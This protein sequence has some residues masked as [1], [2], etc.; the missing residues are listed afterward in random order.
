MESRENALKNLAAIEVRYHAFFK[1]R[2]LHIMDCVKI[3]GKKLVSVHVVNQ[4][5]PPEIQSEIDLVCWVD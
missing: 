1:E 5:L 2:A 3:R 4:S